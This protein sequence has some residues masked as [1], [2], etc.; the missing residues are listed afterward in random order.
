M[1]TTSK[2]PADAGEPAQEPGERRPG[3][4]RPDLLGRGAAVGCTGAFR[5]SGGV[6]IQEF[7]PAVPEGPRGNDST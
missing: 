6:D 3:E 2:T 1:T 4:R 7:L 5:E